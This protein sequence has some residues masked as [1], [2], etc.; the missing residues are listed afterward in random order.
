MWYQIAEEDIERK[1]G[2][3]PPQR[4][5]FAVLRQAIEDLIGRSPDEARRWF[6]TDDN[7]PG[8][9][10]FI[11]RQLG[12]SPEQVRRKIDS[13]GFADHWR[14]AAEAYRSELRN[15]I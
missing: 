15:S 2:W 14:D 13:R 5:W 4:L 10:R 1:H 3:G 12:I 7:R 11:C 9:F 6:L 8:G